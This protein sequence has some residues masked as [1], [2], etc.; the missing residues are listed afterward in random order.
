MRQLDLADY[1]INTGSF[2][3][4]VRKKPLTSRNPDLAVFDRKTLVEENG[5]YHSAPQ[6]IIEVFSPGNRAKD[7]ARLRE[8]Y[9]SIGAREYWEVWSARRAL[10]VLYLDSAQYR[11]AA[12]V[13]SGLLKPRAF[14][15]VQVD[16]S[17][18]WPD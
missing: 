17:T 5:Y 6:L 2:G 13:S 16:I 18:I 9:A 15:H 4:V 7:R 1:D 14:P 12:S 8:D 10:E 11:T 3:L